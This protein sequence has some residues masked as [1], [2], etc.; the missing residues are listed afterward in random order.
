MALFLLL[1]LSPFL[2][3]GLPQRL[4]SNTKPEKSHIPSPQLLP[5]LPLMPMLILMDIGDAKNVTPKLMPALITTGTMVMD[6][7][8]TDTDILVIMVSTL[9]IMVFAITT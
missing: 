1:P 6:T 5:M 2:I 8:I 3:S 9:L 4:V 7:H